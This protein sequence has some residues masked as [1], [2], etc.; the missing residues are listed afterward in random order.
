MMDSG[1]ALLKVAAGELEGAIIRMTKH[2][3][4]DLAAPCAV[5]KAAGGRFSDEAGKPLLFGKGF[6]DFEYFVA[7]NGIAHERVL[8]LI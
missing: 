4:W 5:L 8:E 6:I 3:E 2:Q 1:L 7:S